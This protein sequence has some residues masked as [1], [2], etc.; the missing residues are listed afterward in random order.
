MCYLYFS[1]DDYLS[2]QF[3]NKLV[4]IVVVV[5][6]IYF[7]KSNVKEV[8]RIL[9]FII[10]YLIIEY[11]YLQLKQVIRVIELDYGEIEVVRFKILVEEKCQL[12]NFNQSIM[13]I[14]WVICLLQCNEDY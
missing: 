7:V 10:E 14:V 5:F 4:L 8:I 2:W 6:G 12:C 11:L 1:S 13:D 3:M 9:I